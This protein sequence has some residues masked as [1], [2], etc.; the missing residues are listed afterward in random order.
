MINAGSNHKDGASALTPKQFGAMQRALRSATRQNLPV[1]QEIAAGEYQCQVWNESSYFA[2]YRID[3]A[4]T[5]QYRAL[6]AELAKIAKQY[7]Q[8]SIAMSTINI[9]HNQL[10]PAQP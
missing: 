7:Q 4:K 5:S 10:I 6:K 8:E 9:P 1:L 2:M 3:K